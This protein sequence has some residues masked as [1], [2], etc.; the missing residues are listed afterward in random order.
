MRL[1]TVLSALP[2]ADPKLLPIMN[3][4]FNCPGVYG[5]TIFLL[6]VGQLLSII[7]RVKS[8]KINARHRTKL[9]DRCLL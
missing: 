7:L 2:S 5:R 6:E 9:L 1:M 4:M 8:Y 3:T